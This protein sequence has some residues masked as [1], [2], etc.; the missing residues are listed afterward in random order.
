MGSADSCRQF[1]PHSF[2]YCQ[3][4]FRQFS[5]CSASAA[6]SAREP[7]DCRCGWPL[8]L[9]HRSPWPAPL[10]ASELA[11][12]LCGPST[13]RR[14][15]WR[16][17]SAGVW[18]S[19]AREER[20]ATRTLDDAAVVRNVAG[21][22]VVVR[23][24]SFL[25][26]YGDDPMGPAFDGTIVR[27]SAIALSLLCIG[28]LRCARRLLLGSSGLSIGANLRLVYAC[29]NYYY[30]PCTGRVTIALVGSISF[31]KVKVEK[32]QKII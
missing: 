17:P 9:R 19:W 10:P 18:A 3:W 2:S 15:Y 5:Y 20:V 30:D 23:T 25:D 7:L 21:E 13:C 27:A 16:G 11:I 24:A 4:Q 1:A 6:I 12:G 14:I 29:I 28:W 26:N 22:A 8:R 32:M 31:L